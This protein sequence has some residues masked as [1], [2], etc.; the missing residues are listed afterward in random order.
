MRA[1][2]LGFIGAARYA[3]PPHIF[4]IDENGKLSLV[5]QRL[6]ASKKIG[7]PIDVNP[8]YKKALASSLDDS[9]SINI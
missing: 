4:H 8:L 3:R 6:F 7:L 2:M 9:T 1:L 5:N